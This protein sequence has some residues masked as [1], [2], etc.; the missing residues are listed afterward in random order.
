M[1]DRGAGQQELESRIR[2]ALVEWTGDGPRF[3]DRD[4]PGWEHAIHCTAASEGQWCCIDSGHEKFGELVAHLAAAVG[5][6]ST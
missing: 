4:Q 2:A 5:P 1:T 3:P 6:D